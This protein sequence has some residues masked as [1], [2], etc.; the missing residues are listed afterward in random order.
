MTRID[1]VT[2]V[3]QPLALIV[4]D[5]L[6]NRMNARLHMERSGYLV[7]EAINGLAAQ[8]LLRDTFFH[9]AVVDL[10]MPLMNGEQLIAWID[11][12]PRLNAMHVVVSSANSWLTDQRHEARV[13]HFSAKPIQPGPFAALLKSLLDRQ[14]EV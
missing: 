12:T 10:R 2:G 7:Y 5:E 9:L 1:P 6:T 13:D 8:I 11:Q 3:V 4:E 14:R